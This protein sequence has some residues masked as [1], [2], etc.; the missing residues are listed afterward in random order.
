MDLSRREALR[1]LTLLVGGALSAPTVGALLSGCRA[2]PPAPEWTPEVLTPEEL[3]LLEL[4]VERVIPT[5]DTPGAKDVGVPAF[6]DLLLSDWAE[7]DESER[8]LAG[9]AALDLQTEEAHG[10]PFREASTEQQNALLARL[11]HE[12]V[13][14]REEEAEPLP[15]FATL[16]EWTLVGYYTSEVGA[17]EEL[18]WLAAPGRYDGDVP[19]EEV[20]RAWA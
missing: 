3:E 5:T 20:G 19:L 16:K 13:A 7:P 14:A 2:E 6:I 4:L 8:F 10:V 12:A 18:Q 11:D 9:L 17:T 15:F 1:R